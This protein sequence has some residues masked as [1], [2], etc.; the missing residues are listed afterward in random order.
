MHLFATKAPRDEFNFRRLSQDATSNNPAALIKAEWKSCR[1]LKS[2][3]MAKHY[4]N[5]PQNASVLCRGATVKITGKNFEPDWGLYNN[6]VGV[7]QEIVF[8]PGKDPNNGDQPAYIAVRFEMCCGPV[9]DASDPKVVPIPMATRRCNMGCCTVKYCPLELSYGMTAHTFQGQSA[10][11]VSEGQ[12]K[13]AV[14]RII[15]DPGNKIFEGN[16]PGILYM[17]ASRATTVGTEEEASALYFSGQNMNKFRV[18]NL[19][20]Q[21]DGVTPYKKVRLRDLWVK[22]FD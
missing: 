13:N 7:V 18:I 17:G 6:G 10:G 9:W 8:P 2:Q 16:N 3:S 1:R 21:R 19:K 4:D 14:D 5:P 15:F 20:L 11:P 22:R 12:P